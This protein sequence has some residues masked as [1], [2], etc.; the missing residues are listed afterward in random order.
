MTTPTA[1][2]IDAPAKINLGLEILGKR[3]DLYHNIRTVMAM[4]DLADTVT[5]SVDPTGQGCGM[6]NVPLCDNLI[7][8]ALDAFREAVPDSPQLG[9]RIEKRI[10][11]AAG[12]GGASSDAA[13]ALIAANRISGMPCTRTQLETLARELG[14]DVSFFLGSPLAIA[15]GRGD[16]LDPLMPAPMEVLLVVPAIDI[17]QKTGTLYALIGPD[18]YSDGGQAD[19]VREF[20]AAGQIPSRQTLRN[21][22]NR[23]LATIEPRV[24]DL[25]QAISEL[26]VET[27]GL[28]GA[29]PAFY[30]LSTSGGFEELRKTLA[31]RF[32]DWVKL[33]PT[34]TR[35]LPLRGYDVTSNG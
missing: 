12:L 10:P 31:E 20:L 26:G 6:A 2:T 19:V 3:E 33:M 34:R 17:P 7:V 35:Q 24:L 9:W 8:C 16:L 22:F 21:A 30:V 11:M 13:A 1:V 5:V 14:S 32:G 25:Q 27:F 23:P 4:L 18:D 28:S 29:G 15:S